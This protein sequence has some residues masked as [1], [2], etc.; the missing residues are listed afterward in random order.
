[1]GT[2]LVDLRQVQGPS[3]G[4]LP[5]LAAY[6]SQLVGEPFQF[7][8]VS[9]GDELTLHFGDLRPGRSSKL[10]HKLYGTYILGLR[11]SRWVLKVGAEPVVISGGVV[12]VATLPSFGDP[13]RNED[14]EAGTFLEPGSRVLAAAPFVVKPGGGFGLQVR[15]ADGSTLL[16]LPAPAEPEDPADEDLPPLADWELSTPRGLLSAGPDLEWSFTPATDASDPQK[17]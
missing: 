12:S 3:Q 6:L 2:N 17:S 9:Y 10:K 7:L 15:M 1:M 13:L 8:R 5:A 16:S 11:G 4:N 14:L